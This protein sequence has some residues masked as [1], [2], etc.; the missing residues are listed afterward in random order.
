MKVRY[1]YDI[2]LSFAG[3][4]RDYVRV[5]AKEL[6]RKGIR[7]FYDEFEEVNLWGKNL[8]EY[9][10]DVY[11]NKSNYCVVFI[12][13]H[14]A[15]KVWPTHE[16]RSAQSRALKENREYILPAKFDDTKLPGEGDLISFIDLRKTSP[17]KL[18]ELIEKKLGISRENQEIMEDAPIELIES[19]WTDY[20][21]CTDPFQKRELL[22]S[23]AIM[24]DKRVRQVLENSEVSEELLHIAAI[25][26]IPEYIDVAIQSLYRDEEFAFIPS[27]FLTNAINI[28]SEIEPSYLKS[29]A[30]IAKHL[31]DPDST[32]G[33][34][35]FHSFIDFI[36]GVGLRN[37]ELYTTSRWI[38]ASILRNGDLLPDD[39]QNRSI[40]ALW[41]LD[42]E[43]KE[44]KEYVRR[45][46]KFLS[47]FD[48]SKD[49]TSGSNQKA[50]S[51]SMLS[52]IEL[53][54]LKDEALEQAK[55]YIKESKNI[56]EIQLALG[57][58]KHNNGT[59]STELSQT[60]SHTIESYNDNASETY[61]MSNSEKN[62]LL[63]VI[64]VVTGK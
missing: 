17:E 45:K 60:V 61:R 14:Y 32:F 33:E 51:L 46:I 30:L 50:R 1:D 39:Y 19:I 9:L 5:V 38:I 54:E 42:P 12:S 21:N 25:A 56:Y 62:S 53:R 15:D 6:R 20:E 23:A 8:Y 49:Y 31:V 55:R 52:K 47:S 16:R 36:E 10:S 59:I 35:G 24:G 43:S 26:P 40:I 27:K 2:A 3:E 41:R 44:A 57:L 64:E 7:I 13:E 58:I 48:P 37:K 28:A 22:E 18:A 4:D 34:I 63:K 29:S 11:N